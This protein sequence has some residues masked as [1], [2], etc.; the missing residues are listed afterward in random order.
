MS[1]LSEVFR[2]ISVTVIRPQEKPQ[3]K[4]QENPQEKPQE[5]PQENPQEKTQDN[6]PEFDLDRY[7]DSD[8][9][10]VELE[11][12]QSISL[13]KRKIET[14]RD[15][16]LNSVYEANSRYDTNLKNLTAI[17]NQVTIPALV[18]GVDDL[19][20]KM[21]DARQAELKQLLNSYNNALAK[22]EDEM[23]KLTQSI[24]RNNV[25]DSLIHKLSNPSFDLELGLALGILL[26]NDNSYCPNDDDI[27]IDS[28]KLLRCYFLKELVKSDVHSLKLFEE[29][30][31][32][33]GREVLLRILTLRAT[34]F[35]SKS[36]EYTITPK[37]NSGGIKLTDTDIRH[38]FTFDRV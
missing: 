19:I 28:D 17:K 27:G 35:G 36:S 12:S 33:L 31:I 5:N 1:R 4:P 8:N 7:P 23:K 34:P 16:Y 38:S 15:D 20:S 29:H 11:L 14:V 13:E 9:R 30:L 24:Y 22:S 18:A 21:E 10:A 2:D 3:E 26:H 25:I 37:P 32:S 6:I